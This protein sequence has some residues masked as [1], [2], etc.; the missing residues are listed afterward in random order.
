[1]RITTLVENTSGSEKIKPEH[2]LS[3]YIE[4]QRHKILFD[5]GQTDAFA[6]NA[7]MLGIDLSGVDF[8]VV[9]HGH[10]DHGGGLET[11]LRINSKAP[12]YIHRAAF[13]DHYNGTQKY[14]GL[15]RSL[16]SHCRLIL[17]EGNTR[18]APGIEL[19]D[20]N[21]Q[22]WRFDSCGLNRMDAGMY[23]P[24]DFRH[25]QYL[26][27]TEGEKRVLISGCS[28]KGILNIAGFFRP[29]LL[30]GG[31][32][33]NKLE[34]TQALRHIAHRLMETDA[35]YATG[36]CTGNGQF[37]VMKALMGESLQSISAGTVI[38]I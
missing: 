14:I 34:D 17:T 28:H 23:A 32:H 36:H 21:R 38:E 18:I 4:T 30:V 12:V 37:A 35:R 19:F 22:N 2:G 31:F 6:R 7:R 8:A 13:G 24:D 11:F 25:E 26:Q 16:Q 15:D 5:M 1:M 27:I 29:H 20:C 10:Y 3:L 33:L 9:S